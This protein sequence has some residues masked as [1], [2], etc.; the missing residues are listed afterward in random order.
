MMLEFRTL[1]HA[2]ALELQMI[3]NMMIFILFM[4]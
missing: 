4:T 3:G 2:H 1:T